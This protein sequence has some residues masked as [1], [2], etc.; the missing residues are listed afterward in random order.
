MI[1]NTLSILVEW[2]VE[3]EV[4]LH[5]KCV[6]IGSVPK[7]AKHLNTFIAEQI[8]AGIVKQSE[9]DG[10]YDRVDFGDI[11]II[12]ATYSIETIVDISD[13]SLQW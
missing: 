3:G 13:I 8:K 10:V 1:R 4:K 5:S 12:E 2:R 9:F 11:A 7:E 6:F